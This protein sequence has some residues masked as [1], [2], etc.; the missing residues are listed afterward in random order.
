ML[1]ASVAS[2]QDNLLPKRLQAPFRLQQE[3]QHDI[4]E[5][6]RRY[7]M[8]RLNASEL[9]IPTLRTMCMPPLKET[10]GGA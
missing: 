1:H 6:S 7:S 9:Y 4:F 3:V 10:S 8:T 2:K 5:R